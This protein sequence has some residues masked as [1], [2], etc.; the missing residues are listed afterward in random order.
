AWEVASPE[1]L[2]ILVVEDSRAMRGFL[3][4]LL[5]ARD[6]DVAAFPD[7][8]SAWEAVQQR[9]FDLAILDWTLPGKIEGLDLCRLMR[10]MRDGNRTMI[11]LLTARTGKGDFEATL[12]A[13]ADDYLAKPLEPDVLSLRLRIAERHARVRREMYRAQRELE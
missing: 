9:S 3:E 6:H 13:G 10:G 1:Q 2:S 4:K 11:L 12:E 8:E 5:R 7:G